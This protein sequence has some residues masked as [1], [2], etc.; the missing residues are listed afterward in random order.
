MQPWW[1]RRIEGDIKVLRN[2]PSKGVAVDNFRP[3]SCL[4]LMWKLLTGVIA[5][6]MYKYLDEILPEE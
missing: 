1:K 3:I 6:V 4:P 2:D 5:E